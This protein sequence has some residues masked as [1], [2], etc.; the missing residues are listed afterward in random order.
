M[1]LQESLHGSDDAAM[2]R[3]VK[4]LSVATNLV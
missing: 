2:M 1:V 4:D 3:L